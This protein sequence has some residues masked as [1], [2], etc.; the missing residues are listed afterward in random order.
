MGERQRDR[1]RYTTPPSFPIPLS[2]S[3]SAEVSARFSTALGVSFPWSEEKGFDEGCQ[4][5]L[6]KRLLIEMVPDVT[7]F[8]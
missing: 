5:L 4:A 6:S 2:Y 8:Q 3:A 1:S 7:L